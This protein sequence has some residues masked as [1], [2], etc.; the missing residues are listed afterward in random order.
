[1]GKAG[2]K[3]L[4]SK[5]PQLLGQKPFPILLCRYYILKNKKRKVVIITA[6]VFIEAVFLLWPL[7][8]IATHKGFLHLAT[9]LSVATG[10]AVGSSY[11]LD[12]SLGLNLVYYSLG[13]GLAGGLGFGLVG[14]DEP[15]ER[16]GKVRKRDCN[17]LSAYQLVPS[18]PR[19]CR[20]SLDY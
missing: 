12:Y 20:N 16:Q 10:F 8:C 7:A 9:I 13:P 3:E 17:I 18:Y 19:K 1:M 11:F 4:R 2:K 5:V 6:A 14:T 15:G